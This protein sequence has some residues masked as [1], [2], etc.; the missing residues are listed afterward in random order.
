MADQRAISITQ[1]K[2]LKEASEW[3]VLLNDTDV[4]SN[5]QLQQDWQVWLQVRDENRWAWQRIDQMQSRLQPNQGRLASQTLELSH[6]QQLNRRQAL[7]GLACVGALFG[8]GWSSYQHDYFQA[9]H[10]SGKGEVKMLTLSDQTQLVL[11]ST[12]AVRIRFD[13]RQRRIELLKGE[14]M[15]SSGHP[16]GE[17]RPLSVTTPYGQIRALGT[18]FAVALLNHQQRLQVFEDRVELNL[19]G[20]LTQWSAG[21]QITFSATE[22]TSQQALADNSDSWTSGMLVIN[23]QSL[24]RFLQTL[25]DYRPGHISIDPALS[26]YRIS[27]GFRID[28]TDQA[29]QAVAKSFPVEVSYLTPYW[30]RV[31]HAEKK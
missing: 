28:N 8:I 25:A 16:A 14:V 19:N 29:L 26:R 6:H 4:S 12:S 11:H 15:V 17:Q 7:K 1:R 9:D 20:V 24:N 2:A 21:K 30:V 3:F 10:Y 22:I 23:N 18:R 5:L 27:G 31:R 13:Q